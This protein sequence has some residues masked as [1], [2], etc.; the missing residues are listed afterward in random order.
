[1]TIAVLAVFV[2]LGEMMCGSY[3]V[4]GCGGVGRPSRIGGCF[5]IYDFQKCNDKMAMNGDGN[6][7]ITEISTRPLLQKQRIILRL[8]S[9]WPGESHEAW[10]LLTA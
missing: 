6:I 7:K 4:C 8:K 3:G 1:M 2:V 5:Q 10:N 9:S